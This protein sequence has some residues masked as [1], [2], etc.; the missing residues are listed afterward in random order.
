MGG[1]IH[2]IQLSS[3]ADKYY[4]DWQTFS[5]AHPEASWFQSHGFFS[6]IQ[7]WP[8]ARA[9]LLLAMKQPHGTPAGP[10]GREPQDHNKDRITG[11]LLAVMVH[12]EVPGWMSRVQLQGLYKKLT[13]RTIVYGGPL[14]APASREEQQAV[15]GRMLEALQEVVSGQTLYTQFR[16]FF[17]IHPLRS[18][19]K[20]KG[21]RYHKHLNLLPDTSSPETAW[22]N[23]KPN[24]RRQIRLSRQNGAVVISK[25]GADQVDAFYDILKKLYHHQIKKPLPA[26]AFFHALNQPAAHETS[27][28]ASVLLLVMHGQ[29]I[30]GGAACVLLPGKVMHEW[31]AC[32]LD[33]AYKKQRIYPSVMATWAAMEYAASH[34]IPRFDF[35]GMG[36]PGTPY[37]VRTFKKAFGGQWVNHGRLSRVN[38]PLLYGIAE[39]LYNMKALLPSSF[40]F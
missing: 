34:H 8:E 20:E 19:F 40:R 5:L 10:M 1:S 2:I 4:P 36:K 37:G 6:F 18:V 39:L 31:Y 26:R 9:V 12:E 3:S 24:R 32:G 22:K 13:A 7:Q 33:K 15:L 11:S 16:N 38:H 30:I 29:Q 17:D 35:M 28:P 27:P 25:P 21:F 23:L 14:L